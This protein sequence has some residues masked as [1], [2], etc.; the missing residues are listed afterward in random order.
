MSGYALPFQAY[1]YGTKINGDT[2]WSLHNDATVAL[3]VIGKKAYFSVPADLLPNATIPG[4]SVWK[5]HLGQ[6]TYFTP[7]LTFIA[8]VGTYIKFFDNFI[9]QNVKVILNNSEGTT[10]VVMRD[11]E[12]VAYS[13]GS[14]QPTLQDTKTVTLKAGVNYWVEVLFS[15]TLNKAPGFY[16]QDGIEGFLAKYWWSINEVPISDQFKTASIT[17]IH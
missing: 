1:S 14:F 13:N 3:P 9:G 5:Q 12:S 2:E 17:E 16:G 11:W 8:H 6:I 15:T 10:P 7:G 4:G